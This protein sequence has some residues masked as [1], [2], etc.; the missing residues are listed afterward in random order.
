MPRR[1]KPLVPNGHPLV[2]FAVE[3]RAIKERSGLTYREMGVR[4]TY[5]HV[6][7]QRAASGKRRP[8]WPL[9]LAF[10]TACD[11]SEEQ[12]R[13]LK[14]LWMTIPDGPG[15]MP[16]APVAKVE[17]PATPSVE[18]RPYVGVPDEAGFGVPMPDEF[19]T[20]ST[21][22]K[23]LRYVGVSV[24]QDA[25]WQG[26]LRSITTRVGFGDALRRFTELHGF[27]THR[28]LATYIE[29]S[30][31][32]VA[33]LFSGQ[34]TADPTLVPVIFEKLGFETELDP[35]RGLKPARE[36]SEFIAALRRIEDQEVAW[37]LALRGPSRSVVSLIKPGMSLAELADALGVEER[38]MRDHIAD[39]HRICG[40]TNLT[41]LADHLQRIWA[42]SARPRHS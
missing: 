37:Y 19:S 15:G 38:V 39:L 36:V 40:T 42:R 21:A 22:E 25:I 31:P 23:H 5:S 35:E 27:A 30:Y 17:R 41:Q 1:E 2:T 3:M 32:A 18:M 29:K 28:E 34:P 6:Q 8:A 20:G 7:L 10:L 12:K 33:A 13:K 4:A 24:E 14:R 26:S 9:A 11:A 16:A